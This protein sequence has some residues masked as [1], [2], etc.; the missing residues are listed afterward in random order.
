[1]NLKKVSN[2][3]AKFKKKIQ[4]NTREAF[5]AR[6]CGA[7]GEKRGCL[8]AQKQESASNKV[9]FNNLQRK[10]NQSSIFLLS[11]QPSPALHS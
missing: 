1:M 3:L 11:Q 9:S 5:F 6:A 10:R 8:K 7:F 4:T 2:T